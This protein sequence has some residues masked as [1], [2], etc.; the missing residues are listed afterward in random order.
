MPLIHKTK[1]LAYNHVVQELSRY[2]FKGNDLDNA[3]AKAL[4]SF[5]C[6]NTDPLR[7]VFVEETRF[8][9]ET[10]RTDTWMGW[11]QRPKH[12]SIYIQD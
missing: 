12:E 8:N 11:I 5:E 4:S 1:S 3:V 9:Q 2:Y 7:F 10:F 6:A